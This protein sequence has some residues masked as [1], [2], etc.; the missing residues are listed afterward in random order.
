MK[1]SYKNTCFLEEE[2]IK[3]T[4][5]LLNGYIKKLNDIVKKGGYEYDEA[6]LNLPFDENIKSDVLEMAK[7]K[8][9]GNLKYIVVVGIGGSNL[10][11]M[12][13]YQALRGV[14]HTAVSD[15]LPKILFLDTLSQKNFFD[16]TNILKDVKDSSE[17]LINVIS[18]SGS[19]VETIAN[20]ESLFSQLGGK[21]IKDRV[22]ATT[23]QDSLLYE[24]AQKIGVDTL[25]IPKKV[26]GRYSVFSAV[27]LFPLALA[28]IDIE[29]LTKGAKNI[30]GVCLED[31]ISKNPAL[32]SSVLM[33]LHS[34]HGINISNSFFFDPNLNAVGLWYRQLMGES[35]GKK[36]NKE[37]RIVNSGITPIVSLGSTDLHSVAQL[38]FGGPKDK[39]TTFVNV[40]KKENQ[41]FV[42]NDLF[43]E[44]L[45]KGIKGKGFEEI[46]SSIY[47]GTKLAYKNNK[48]PFVEVLLSCLDEFSLGEFLQFKMIEIMYLAELLEVNAFDQPSVE[49]YKKEAR[50]IL[51]K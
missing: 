32:A 42:P 33:F 17:I 9:N 20:F 11:T 5:S 35:L 1:F 27:G 10:G 51:D 28:K 45:V 41:I 38:F 24:F 25:K 13:V 8:S 31:D 34:K 40:E 12:A 22:V 30:A 46:L 14:L 47:E 18:K 36:K 26:G 50:A 37:G 43:F 29:K 6:S 2:D 7:K 4:A 23:D 39:F 48:I 49:E 3:N 15:G 19:T 21:K 44:G 16:L